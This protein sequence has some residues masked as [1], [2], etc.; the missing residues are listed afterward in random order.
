MLMHRRHWHYPFNLM[1][2]SD[3]E[4]LYS[5]DEEMNPL[6]HEI[7]SRK[8]DPSTVNISDTLNW[9]S[10]SKEMV[11]VGLTCQIKREGK[12]EVVVRS[13]TG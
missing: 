11:G 6:A 4:A 1:P 5:Q 3:V 8:I 10:K 2:S 7:I 13:R 9:P 12:T